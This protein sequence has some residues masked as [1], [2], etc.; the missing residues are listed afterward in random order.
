LAL[1]FVSMTQKQMHLDA[2]G[3]TSMDITPASIRDASFDLTPM[4]CNPVQVEEA[5]ATI[6]EHLANDEPV[7]ADL[8]DCEFDTVSA[9]FSPQ[10]VATFFAALRQDLLQ[11]SETSSAPAGESEVTDR[12]G[13]SG[14]APDGD[15]D[16]LSEAFSVPASAHARRDKQDDEP[17]AVAPRPTAAS[18]TGSSLPTAVERTKQAVSELETF[19]IHQMEEAK[20]ALRLHIDQTQTDCQNT[21]ETART[22]SDQALDT[23]RQRA[24]VLLDVATRTTNQLRDR[25]DSELAAMRAAFEDELAHRHA[26]I[27]ADLEALVT[28]AHA[29]TQ[30]AHG[31]VLEVHDDVRAS[32]EDARTVLMSPANRLAA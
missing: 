31:Q 30:E 27:Q 24:E 19:V 11:P 1:L 25:F 15:R 13:S 7:P 4:G 9:G 17:I 6:A 16:V 14:A 29:L 2:S 3:E 26:A 22:V 21:L 28:E 23:A 10:E 12:V 32:L 8:L 5:L 20:A 18:A